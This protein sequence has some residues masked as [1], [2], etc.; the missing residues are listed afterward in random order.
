[1]D[2]N[3]YKEPDVIIKSIKIC[4]ENQK[5]WQGNCL[6]EETDDTLPFFGVIVESYKFMH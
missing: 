1:M 4:I 5:Q 3:S 6:D 2:S